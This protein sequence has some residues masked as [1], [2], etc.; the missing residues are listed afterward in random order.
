M[1]KKIN[2]TEEEFNKFILK[3]LIHLQAHQLALVPT[4]I[5]MC[6]G[7]SEKAKSLTDYYNYQVGKQISVLSED[8]FQHRGSFGIDD[9]LKDE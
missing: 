6:E 7:D 9:V 8:L 1:A 2:L 3:S 4:M 5:A